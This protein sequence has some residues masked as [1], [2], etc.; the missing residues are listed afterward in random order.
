MRSSQ[1]V[2]AVL[3]ALGQRHDVIDAQRVRLGGLTTTQRTD[4]FLGQDLLPQALVL[5]P[6]HGAPALARVRLSRGTMACR[7]LR[8]SVL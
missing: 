4:L 7:V 6:V 5:R 1:V 8:T 2:A 3:A